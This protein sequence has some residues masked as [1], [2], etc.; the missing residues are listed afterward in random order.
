GTT[1]AQGAAITRWSFPDRLGE[2]WEPITDRFNADGTRCSPFCTADIS[3]VAEKT[4]AAYGRI[5]FG[6]DF[7]NGW[8]LAGNFGVRYV[9]TTVESRG[10]ITTADPRRFDALLAGGNGDGIVQVSEIQL[11]CDNAPNGAPG[12]DFCALSAG[13]KAAF[14]AAHTGQ[15]IIDDRDITFDHWLPSFNAKL[16]V[17]GGL[18][19]RA[20]V[21]KG[22]SR[23]DLALFRAG[24]AISDNTADLAD[25]G[26]LESGPLFQLFTGNRN[27]QAT[28]SWNYDLSAEW[29]FD[30]VGSITV[31]AF[32]KD[33]KGIVSSGSNVVNY[34]SSN[35]D[36]A[37]EVNGPSNE[38]G[39]KLKGVEISH[40]QTYDFLPGLLSGLGS[41]LT[42]TYVDAGDFTNPDLA[43]NRGTFASLQPL[44][45]VSK[46]TVNATVFFEKGPLALRAAYNW[47]SDFLIT[48]RD[49]IFPFSPIWQESSG[50]LDA[51]IFYSVT[52][53]IKV[54]VQG[55]N[56]LDSVT[57]TSQV[58]DFDGTRLTR[59]AFRNDR[60][61]T[62]LAR[63][64]F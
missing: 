10:T 17:G 13:R 35:G 38:L 28:Q 56:L 14:A 29:Y 39:G 59:S 42:Y 1:A 43:G 22:I 55:V 44:Q 41:Q 2:A 37:V 24:G 58:V 4:K 31:S 63:F 33:I 61:Y 51:S 25:D 40:Q 30:T 45:G 60:R 47:R 36:I 50:Q 16:D 34:P 23:P 12:L 11:V 48:P 5:D 27:V 19:F 3:D 52:D 57:R 46:H 8:N 64:D 20:A 7:S 26:T 49:D 62:F 54:G 15:V 32:L 21:S 18:L 9:H 6:R 53:N